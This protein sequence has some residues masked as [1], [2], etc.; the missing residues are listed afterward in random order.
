M[1]ILILVSV[2]LL[3]GC[4]QNVDRVGTG[5]RLEDAQPVAPS[6]QP[7]A[8][9]EGME[10]DVPPFVKAYFMHMFVEALYSKPQNKNPNPNWASPLTDPRQ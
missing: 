5:E 8:R 3:S 2:L 7:L 10:S 6:A 9:P 1:K 4:D